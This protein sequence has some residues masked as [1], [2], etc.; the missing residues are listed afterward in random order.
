MC[1]WN[2]LGIRL[3]QWTEPNSFPGESKVPDEQAVVIAVAQSMQLFIL[4][5]EV[6]PRYAYVLRSAGAWSELSTCAEL[7]PNRC[8]SQTFR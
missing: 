6:M 3:I 5:E 2:A 4:R 7:F 1:T 8:G